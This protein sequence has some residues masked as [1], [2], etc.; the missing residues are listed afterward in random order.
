M[1]QKSFEGV[2]QSI[3]IMS[4]EL[5][6]NQLTTMEG[7]EVNYHR[8]KRE[9]GCDNKTVNEAIQLISSGKGKC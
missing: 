2:N 1:L 9:T 3:F 7:S 5:Y 6:I 8:F 4:F